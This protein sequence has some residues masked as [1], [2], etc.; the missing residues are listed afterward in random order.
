MRSFL[1]ALIQ[2]AWCP[3][4]EGKLGRP[5]GTGKHTGSWWP[6]DWRD[7][8]A[9]HKMPRVT[10]GILDFFKFVIPPELQGNKFLLFSDNSFSSFFY[11][12]L[13]QP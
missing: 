9:S 12:F 6:C 3:Y 5:Q 2:Y 11:I 7:V 4:K 1:C 10:P 13:L 8:S